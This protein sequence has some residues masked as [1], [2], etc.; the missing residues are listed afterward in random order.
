MLQTGDE[1]IGAV[2]VCQ[3]VRHRLRPHGY[4]H[5]VRDRVTIDQHLVIGKAARHI[6]AVLP[7]D[8]DQP[9]RLMGRGVAKLRVVLEDDELPDELEEPDELEPDELLEEVF[10][11]VLLDLPCES[12]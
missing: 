4:R 8:R 1:Q 3:A 6:H 12:K 5:A 10:E 7:L 2:I 11:G 9:E